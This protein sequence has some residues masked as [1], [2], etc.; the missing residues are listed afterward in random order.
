MF[1]TYTKK[2]RNMYLLGMLGQNMIYNII[3]TGLAYYFQS[4]IFIPAMAYSIFFAVARVWDAINDPMMGTIVDRTKTKYGKCRPYLMWCPALICLIT[5]LTFVNGIYSSGNK[6]STNVIIIAWAAISYILWGMAYTVGDIPLWGITSLMTESEK[7]RSNILA[8]ARIAGGLGG[9]IVL[10]TIVPVSQ[11]IGN[12]ITE[13]LGGDKTKGLQYGFIIV[14]VVLTLIGSALFQLVGIFTRERVVSNN[15]KK[16][17]IKQ[18]FG[19]M[20]KCEPFRRILISGI[21]RSPTMLLMTVAM[22]LVA[23]Y[24]G[25]NGRTDYTLYLI[26]LGGAIFGGQFIA[27]AFTPKLAE[28]YEKKKLYNTF[29][30]ASGIPFVLIFVSYLIAP[31]SLASPFWLVVCFVL[32]AAAGAGMGSITVLQS[33]MTAD[34]VDYEEYHTGHRPD[35]VFFSGQSFVTK[36][37]SGIASIITGIAYSVVGF[38]GD[39]VKAVNDAL[40][41]GAS[42]KSDPAFDKYRLAMF[43]LCSIPPAI[44]MFISVIPMRKYSLTNGEHQR[45]LKSLNEKRNAN[46]AADGE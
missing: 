22:S 31:S 18:N 39:A 38:S 30:F 35:G 12:A 3:G 1:K 32:F 19:I 2:E 20:W 23:Y 26:V 4:V 40:Y 9:G 14:A 24:Y 16:L 46:E 8:L 11:A 34:T 44:G 42:F 7:D 29:S 33:V 21:L 25:D 17:T 43:F 5:I 41:A 15:E 36:L 6:P 28:K 13:A 45:I 37:S 27:M 10:L